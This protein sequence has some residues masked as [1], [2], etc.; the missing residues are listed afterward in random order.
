M[1]HSVDWPF[2]FFLLSHFFSQ[3]VTLLYTVEVNSSWAWW[4]GEEERKEERKRGGE[5]RRK[6]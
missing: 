6:F 3:F 2:L 1:C 5:R 4:G